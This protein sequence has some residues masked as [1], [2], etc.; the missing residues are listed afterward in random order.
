MTEALIDSLAVA[1]SDAERA[2]IRRMGADLQFVLAESE[3][4]L[5]IQHRLYELGYSTLALFSVI[6]D[7][8]A[9]VRTFCKEQMPLDPAT[10]GLPAPKKAM[11][12][13]TT[14]Q[15]IAAWQ[16]AAQRVTE[17]ERVAAESRSQRLP[18]LVPRVT[19]LN[20]RRRYETA[21]G[22]TSDSVFPCN[23]LIEKVFEEMEEG[24]WT[25][26]SLTELISVEKSTDDLSFTEISSSTGVVKVRKAPKALPMP[27]STE[28]FRNRISTLSI[29][30]GVCAL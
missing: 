10:G 1:F 15:I 21:H 27:R 29:L 8:K 5:R 28:D 2:D 3:V 24:S 25:A 9:G 6:A 12:L 7:D 19:L 22:R 23:S 11:C 17:T 4:P 14:A 20:L 16:T 13:L 30:L 18:V 26:L